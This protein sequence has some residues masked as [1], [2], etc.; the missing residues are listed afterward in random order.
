MAGIRAMVAG[1][2][3]QANAVVDGSF[4]LCDCAN[5]SFPWFEWLTAATHHRHQH[6]WLEM[7][8]QVGL[9]ET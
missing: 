5:E 1:C 7:I 4:L 8:Q 2:W 3:V 6:G 9:A